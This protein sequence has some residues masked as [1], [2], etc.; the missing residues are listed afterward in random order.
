MALLAAFVPFAG[1]NPVLFGVLASA[2]LLV[3]G[4]VQGA[5]FAT[6]PFIARGAAEQARANGTVAQLGNLTATVGPPV[7]GWAIGIDGATGFAILVSASSLCGPVVAWAARGL[8]AN[9]AILGRSA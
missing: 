6:I 7:F 5:C 2:L 1:P 8:T 4:M 9:R 3:S